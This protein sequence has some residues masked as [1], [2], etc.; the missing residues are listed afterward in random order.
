MG[1]RVRTRNRTRRRIAIAIAALAL[2]A[3]ASLPSAAGA[4]IIQRSGAT[5]FYTAGQ[6][7][8]NDVRV[9]RDVLLGQQVLT[10]TDDDAVPFGTGGNLCDLVNGVG[11][12]SSSGVTRVVVNVRDKDD[13]VV[14]ALASPVGPV[15][16]PTT[17]IGGRG[18]DV[19][20]G[21]R[22]KDRL[23]GNSGRDSLRGRRGRDFYKGG[24]GS[25]VIQALD[26]KADRFISCGDG[27]RDLIRAD[28]ID[29]R[30]KSCELGSRKRR[31][32]RP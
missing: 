7:E 31:G 8:R 16:Q 10:F 24:R 27:R 11:M 25:D 13:T 3:L 32:K 4:A 28:G 15:L 19:L 17:L 5:I 12:C 1:T 6:G 2:G 22:G 20:V 29:P 23:K 30:P 18:V 14:V 21:G 9:G 26:G